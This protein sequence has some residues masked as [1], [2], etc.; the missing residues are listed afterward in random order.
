MIRRPPRST[1]FPYTTLF[2]SLRNHRFGAIPHL[3]KLASS[4]LYGGDTG[5]PIDVLGEQDLTAGRHPGEP[6]CRGSHTGREVTRVATAVGQ[7]IDVSAG[8][9]LIAHQPAD[10]R[11][12]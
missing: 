9:R 8:E 11:D 5:K 1:L 7:E 3:K 6:A 10:E 12:G 2:R 4:G